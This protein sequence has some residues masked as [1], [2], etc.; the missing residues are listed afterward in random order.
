MPVSRNPDKPDSD[1]HSCWAKAR[2][3]Q[4]RTGI[5][6]GLVTHS[7][8]SEMCREWGTK[9]ADEFYQRMGGMSDEELRA[10]VETAKRN[11]RKKQGIMVEDKIA[12][13]AY[14]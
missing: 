3:I 12:E 9:N 1:D 7:V 5:M 11:L 14:Q 4:R 8:I 6:L 10:S 13:F 2:E